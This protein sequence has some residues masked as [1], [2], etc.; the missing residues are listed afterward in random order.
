MRQMINIVKALSG[1]TLLRILNLLL[2]RECC[3]YE[4][5]QTLGIS[6]PQASH[7]LSKLYNV[8]ILKR[9]RE[10]VRVIYSV[11]TSFHSEIIKVLKEL[12]ENNKVAEMERIKLHQI[13]HLKL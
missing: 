11:D 1:E 5:T 13:E 8:G 10:G 6:Q 9:R 3:I 12:L 4:V 7:D 2:E